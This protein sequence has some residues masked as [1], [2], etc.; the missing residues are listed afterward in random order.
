VFLIGVDLEGVYT[1]KGY[2][3][4]PLLAFHGHSRRGNDEEGCSEALLLSTCAFARV[5]LRSI[6]KTSNVGCCSDNTKQNCSI[7]RGYK[8]GWVQV[9]FFFVGLLPLGPYNQVRR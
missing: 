7:Q 4:M 8:H 3:S 5:E 1:K 2:K 6:T 9:L